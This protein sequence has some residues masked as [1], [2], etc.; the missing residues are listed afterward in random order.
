MQ[1]YF[2]QITYKG[3][4][5][6]GWQV[7]KNAISVQQ[8][9]N[10]KLSILL[11]EIINVVGAGR[12]DT[13]VHAEYFM[14]HFDVEKPILDSALFLDK[15]N[16]LLPMDIAVCQLFKVSSDANTRFNALS[17]TYE[18]RITRKK[19]PF[20]T[21]LAWFYR[22]QL[23]V[24]LMNQAAKILYEY[25]DFTSFSKTGTQVKT[26][27]C[28]IYEAHW[29][30]TNDNLLIFKI[31]ADRFLRNMVRAIVGTLLYVGME[32][33]SLIDFRKIIESKNRSNAGFSVPAHGLFLTDI[34]YPEGLLVIK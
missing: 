22:V 24:D 19:S 32:K 10:E 17:R 30:E 34:E 28:K 5:Y 2:L 26:N 7:Q 33:L 31:K 25:Q 18:Y 8:V 12:T 9:L 23:N 11:Q 27:N 15:M 16:K 29:F 4:A 13:G 21:D 20:L 3:T 14:L 1:R 6:H